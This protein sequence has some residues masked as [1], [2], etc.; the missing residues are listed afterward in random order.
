MITNP[1][2]KKQ[3]PYRSFTKAIKS[4]PTCKRRKKKRHRRYPL[5]NDVIANNYLQTDFYL[6]DV[7]CYRKIEKM[8]T[9]TMPPNLKFDAS[10][11]KAKNWSLLRH[12]CFVSCFTMLSDKDFKDGFLDPNI[13]EKLKKGNVDKDG[14]KVDRTFITIS[15]KNRPKLLN[16][17]CKQV[18][19]YLKD[20]SLK[21]SGLFAPDP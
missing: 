8:V 15:A 12:C 9:G 3:Q 6:K 21:G 19:D 20:N 7:L 2:N 5:P 16:E 13:V 11:G 14:N 17:L 10:E 18:G 4:K 1:N